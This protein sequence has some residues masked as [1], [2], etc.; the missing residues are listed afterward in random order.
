MGTRLGRTRHSS[1]R[2]HGLAGLAGLAELP[3]SLD[4]WLVSPSGLPG[5]STSRQGRVQ[6]LTIYTYIFL[7]VEPPIQG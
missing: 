5:A 3:S 2:L 7:Y 1:I 4:G 6:G